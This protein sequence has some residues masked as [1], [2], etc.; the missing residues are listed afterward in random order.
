MIKDPKQ[1]LA[2]NYS[3]SNDQLINNMNNEGCSDID[4]CS[5]N[6]TTTTYC[7]TLAA[8]VNTVGSW[9]CD[10]NTGYGYHTP[11]QGCV[12]VDECTDGNFPH[13]CGPNTVCANTVGSFTCT[14]NEGYTAWAAHSGCR[15][16]NECC[17]GHYAECIHTCTRTSDISKYY[18]RALTPL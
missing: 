11:N 7:G 8:C 2:I 3:G 10:C 12:D 15:D 1:K 16:R 6:S 18:D 13:H 17:V 4:E 9:R 14:C 5:V